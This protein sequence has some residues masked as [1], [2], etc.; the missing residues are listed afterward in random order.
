MPDNP[1]FFKAGNLTKCK[2]M[3]SY[4]ESN[5]S[6]LD[7]DFASIEQ[8]NIWEDNESKKHFNS[9]FPSLNLELIKIKPKRKNLYSYLIKYKLPQFLKSIFISG[10]IDLVNNYA[11]AQMQKIL[12]QNKYDIIIISYASWGNL[13]DKR[14]TNAHLILDSHD[15]LTSQYIHRNFEKRNRLVGDLFSE[16]IRLLNRFDEIWTYSIEEKYIF[17]QFTKKTVKLFPVSFPLRNKQTNKVEYDLTYVASD[18]PH[19]IQSA[20]W[21]LEKV[22]PL[23]KNVKTYIVGRICERIGDYPNVIKLGIVED[24]DKIYRNSKITICP[25]LSG[26]GVKIK[27][28]ESLSYGLP[29]VTNPRGVDGLINKSDNGCIVSNNAKE[30]AQNIHL[31][32]TNEDLYKKTSMNAVEYFKNNHA[33]EKELAFL[34]DVFLN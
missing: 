28:L 11:R 27:V 8:N 29:V 4:F 21:Y 18:N 30:F 20:I 10:H 31:L 1:F 6:L 22:L 33:P 32:L 3:L 2:Q 26:T 7:V 15:F 24:I 17:E 12:K 13:I 34:E 9:I 23:L 25:M 5:N 16:E 19:N 14:L